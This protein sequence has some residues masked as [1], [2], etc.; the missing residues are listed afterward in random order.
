MN[1]DKIIALTVEYGTQVLLA[2]AALII[3]WIIINIFCRLFY[4][5]LNKRELD[6]SLKNFLVGL[7]KIIFRVLLIISVAGMVGIKTASF[8]AVVGAL[9][10]A[11]GLA[12]QG[13]LQNFAGGV[14]ILLLKP[15]KT[16]DFI[17]AD[18]SMGTVEAI[19]LFFTTLVT[20]DNKQVLIPNGQISNAKIINFTKKDRRRVELNIGITYGEDVKK[21][22][23]LV[24]NM[25]KNDERVLEEPE[26][27]LTLSSLGDNSVDLTIRFWA[28][29]DDFW[30]LYFEM[31]EKIYEDFPK[32]GLSFPFPQLDVHMTGEE[33]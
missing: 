18:S 27:T 11:V 2:L 15:F 13:T 14:I 29:L 28:K 4:K 3:G 6:H 31:Q 25:L 12:L 9:S 10:L 33:A 16:G 5:A 19:T 32:H 17:E 24:L 23:D 7:V 21:A 30:P 20:T 22:R 26:P 8:I 1:T